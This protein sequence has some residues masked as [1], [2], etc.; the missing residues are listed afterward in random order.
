MPSISESVTKWVMDRSDVSKRPQ[1]ANVSEK[2]RAKADRIRPFMVSSSF[3]Y[4]PH[5]DREMLMPIP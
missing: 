1:E 3:A 4:M 2:I 5:N